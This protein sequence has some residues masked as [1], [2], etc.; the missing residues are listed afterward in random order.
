MGFSLGMVSAP[1]A[2]ELILGGLVGFALHCGLII[3]VLGFFDCLSNGK[4]KSQI[5]LSCGISL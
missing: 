5:F 4:G 1:Y 3:S 2:Y